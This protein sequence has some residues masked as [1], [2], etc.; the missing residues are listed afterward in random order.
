MKNTPT[1]TMMVT[2]TSEIPQKKMVASGALAILSV[3]CKMIIR[4]IFPHHH[5]QHKNL[6]QA[7][8]E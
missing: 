6:A 7:L 2:S 5:F 8:E 3:D 4:A 1:N